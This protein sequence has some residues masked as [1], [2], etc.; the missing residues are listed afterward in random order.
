MASAPE[1]FIELHDVVGL[2]VNLPERELRRGDLGTVIEVFDETAHHPA[3]FIVEFVNESREVCGQQ[4]S[5]TRH[6]SS[7]FTS[8]FSGRPHENNLSG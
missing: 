2:L 3:G 8:I 4:R 1:Q 7:S 5:P 6:S